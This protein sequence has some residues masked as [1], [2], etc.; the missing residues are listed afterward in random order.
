MWDTRVGQS[1]AI[2]LRRQQVLDYIATHP[3]TTYR[4]AG[5]ALG[6]PK[7]TV[8]RDHKAALAAL[9]A[10]A[11]DDYRFEIVARNGVIIEAMMPGV[12]NGKP[13]NAE[14][15]LAAD[16]STAKRLGLDPA[17]K[18]H[19]EVDVTRYELLGISR[20]ELRGVIMPGGEA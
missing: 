3:R 19:V 2:D 4:A 1:T 14:I 11:L 12:L 15:V 13:R 17:T 8:E 5:N 9:R 6:I 16:E 20:D 10:R 7:S 18:Q